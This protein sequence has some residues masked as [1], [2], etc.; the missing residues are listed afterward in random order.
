MRLKEQLVL[1]G[2][3]AMTGC[4]SSS[5]ATPRLCLLTPVELGG[6]DPSAVACPEEPAPLT[7]APGNAY[8]IRHELPEGVEPPGQLHLRIDTPCGEHEELDA[9]Y[10][11][12]ASGDEVGPVVVV[13]RTAPAG[14]ACS[15][16]VTAT[17]ANSSLTSATQPAADG[18]DCS[19]AAPDA[20]PAQPDPG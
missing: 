12:P 7:L 16:V 18:A 4:S 11:L 1:A 2:L 13:A 14:A 15:L 5:P 6:K 20:G 19:C 8:Y 10:G 17:I 3:V 9:S